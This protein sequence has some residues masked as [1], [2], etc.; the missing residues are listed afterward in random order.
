LDKVFPLIGV[1]C[2]F[3]GWSSVALGSFTAPLAWQASADSSVVG[4]EVHFGTDG[5]QLTNVLAVGTNAAAT[6]AGLEAQTPHFFV[7]NSV[8]RA[9]D[10]SPFSNEVA[11]IGVDASAG[12]SLYFPLLPSGY[13]R[14]PIVYRL[15]K[16]APAGVSI[17]PANGFL[18]WQPGDAYSFTTN[19]IN[20]EISNPSD[21]AVNFT[22]TVEIIVEG[23]LNLQVGAV[24]VQAGQTGSLPLTVT[25]SS[26][27]T[28]LQ[29]AMN[30]PADQLLNPTLTFSPPFVSGSLQVQDGL[31]I[32]S[33]QTA[34]DQPFSGSAQVGQ[35][36]F[37]TAADQPQSILCSLPSAGSSASTVDGLAYGNVT[38][39]P[40]EV[41]IVGNQP[42]LRP[43]ASG[44]DTGRSLSLYAIPGSYQLWYS[45][46]LL[47]PVTW[48]P[49]FSYEQTNVVQTVT[50]DDTLP[51]VFYRL[52]QL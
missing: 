46:S 52:Q 14:N 29:F 40:G 39:Q 10:Q 26:T 22:E 13:S 50:L 27:V 36:N 1:I 28:N 5:Q 2:L 37:Q 33:L 9:G 42:M 12:D 51:V 4:Y 11:F 8:D 31:L 21:I 38:V 15:P 35:I 20:V 6:I 23:S 45:T 44:S 24:A 25:T 41:V 49:A 18:S 7:A 32:A 34:A 48:Q 43:Q 3:A 19:F 17:N 30:W 47:D 16:N